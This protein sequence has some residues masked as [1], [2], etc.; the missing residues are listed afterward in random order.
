[1]TYA[2]EYCICFTTALTKNY[3]PLISYNTI[4]KTAPVQKL[5]PPLIILLPATLK[6]H[7][8]FSY[9]SCFLPIMVST[10][11]SEGKCQ[12]MAELSYCPST[13]NSDSHPVAIKYNNGIN[14]VYI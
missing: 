8:F 1:M 6:H 9:C 14:I 10:V 12:N 4:T 13:S 3:L 2:E 5:K 7:H 11:V